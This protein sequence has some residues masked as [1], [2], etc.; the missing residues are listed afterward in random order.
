[1][2]NVVNQRLKEGGGG[3]SFFQK[4]YARNMWIIMTCNDVTCNIGI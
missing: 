4:S 1:M 3:K 2:K